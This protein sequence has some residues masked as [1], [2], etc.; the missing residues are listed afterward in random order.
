MLCRQVILAAALVSSTAF[1]FMSSKPGRSNILT[2]NPC[3]IDGL[4]A[5]SA[6]FRHL[7]RVLTDTGAGASS[8]AW[9]RDTLG[10]A[11]VNIS[12][13][14]VVQDTISC[15]L[16][17]NAWKAFYTALGTEE[18]NEAGYV[19]GGLLLRLTANRYALA[20]AVFHPWTG[21][22]FFVVDSN[23]VMVRNGLM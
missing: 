17:L 10:I 20:V 19:K 16:A 21:V 15:R 14:V 8:F 7:G 2:E 12:S 9:L 4:G 11:G 5:D 1:G 22:T 6:A 23:F 13:I 3:Q 18:A